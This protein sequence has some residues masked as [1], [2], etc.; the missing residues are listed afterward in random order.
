MVPSAR[1]GVVN[2]GAMRDLQIEDT[3]L[4]V[5]GLLSFMARECDAR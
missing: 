2:M 3:Q 5:P 1:G 4:F